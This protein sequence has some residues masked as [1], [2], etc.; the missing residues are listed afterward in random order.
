MVTGRCGPNRNRWNPPMNDMKADA[1]VRFAAQVTRARGHGSG[2]DLSAVRGAGHTEA[3][4][5]E[6]VQHVG[7]NT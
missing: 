5:M 7:L 1:A 2:S 4:V 6:I 3:Q